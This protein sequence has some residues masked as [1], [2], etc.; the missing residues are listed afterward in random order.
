MK[1]TKEQLKDILAR[2]GKTFAQAFISAISVDSIFGVTD[3][4]TLKRIGLSMLIAGIAAGISAIWNMVQNWLY[5][6]ID[7]LMPTEEQLT[8]SIEEGLGLED[9]QI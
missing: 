9:E 7:E 2:A 5:R 4:D 8:E 1:L 3:L 6:K